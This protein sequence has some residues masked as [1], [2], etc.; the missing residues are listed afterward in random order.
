M[1]NVD[2]VYGL[3]LY[4]GVDFEFTQPWVKNYAPNFL[5]F[6]WPVLDSWIEK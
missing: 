3:A 4:A 5:F 1:V 2:Q 6:G